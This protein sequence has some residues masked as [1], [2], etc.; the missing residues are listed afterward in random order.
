MIR[1]AVRCLALLCFA[2][3]YFAGLFFAWWVLAPAALK[4]LVSYGSDVVEPLWSIERYL[5]FVLLLMVCTGLSFQIP[6]LQM[7]LGVLGLV[8]WKKMLSSWRWVVMFSALSGA[9]LTPSTDPITMLL[10][11]AAISALFLFGV[12]LVAITEQFQADRPQ[13]S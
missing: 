9:V 7:L 6:V 13:N 11:S 3:L 1:Y 8:Q 12:G 2:L 10:L 5:D 4:F